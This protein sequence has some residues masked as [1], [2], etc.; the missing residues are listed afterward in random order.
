MELEV[1]DVYSPVG[2]CDNCGNDLLIEPCGDSF[3]EFQVKC[4]ACGYSREFDLDFQEKYL[5]RLNRYVQTW[6]IR[7]TSPACPDGLIVFGQNL[8]TT[9]E[10]MDALAEK[11]NSVEITEDEKQELEALLEDIKN[12]EEAIDFYYRAY[13]IEKAYHYAA[14]KHECI[15]RGGSSSLKCREMVNWISRDPGGLF[16]EHWNIYGIILQAWKMSC[17]VVGSGGINARN[18][19]EIRSLFVE[20]FNSLNQDQYRVWLGQDREIYVHGEKLKPDAQI[21]ALV[22]IEMKAFFDEQQYSCSQA[23]SLMAKDLEKLE[24][25]KG[26]FKVGFFLCFSQKFSKQKLM[27]NIHKSFSYPVRVLVCQA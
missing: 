2:I 20:K 26:K 22:V 18:E 24:K 1:E 16:G 17:A 4:W 3:Q 10:K 6:R 14:N 13:E 21:P 5:K 12:R 7:R 27:A 9:T 11:I 15:I 23:V 19:T 25:Y 8:F